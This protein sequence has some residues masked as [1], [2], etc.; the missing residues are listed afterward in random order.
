MESN[1]KYLG[2]EPLEAHGFHYILEPQQ[3]QYY[4]K[5]T[6][7]YQHGL[8]F[9]GGVFCGLFVFFIAHCCN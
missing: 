9:L 5:G 2:V 4:Q 6:A 8:L 7:K 3:L 1:L